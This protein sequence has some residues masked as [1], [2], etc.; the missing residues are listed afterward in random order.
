MDDATKATW[1]FLM[2][3]KSKVR[4]LFHS[5]Y[6]IVSTQ[7]GVKI[8]TIRTNNAKEFDMPNFLNSHGIIH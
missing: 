2:R 4:Q 3:S 1:L 6:A 8:K 7:I 5:F